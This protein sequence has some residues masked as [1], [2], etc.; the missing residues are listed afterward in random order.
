MHNNFLQSIDTSVFIFL[1]SF[2][3]C[4][5]L[6]YFFVAIT[7]IRFW[8]IPA[9]FAVTLYIAKERKHALLVI[10]LVLVTVA[11]SDPVSSQIFKHS[12][13]RLRPCN[14]DVLVPGGHFLFGIKN[15]LSFPS[16]HATNMFAV[17]AL[18][19]FF[20]PRKWLYF[21]GFASLIGFSRIYDGVHYPGDVL[22]GAVLGVIV[23]SLVY[24]CYNL[25]RKLRK[26]KT[27]SHNI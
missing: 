5:V 4:T 10:I 1:N 25:S 23:G 9:A 21:F 16:S 26:T 13:H 22:G 3:S 12:F 6:N 15:S 7:D 20:Y 8:L 11:I 19:T 14:I 27:L 18:F 2:L 24:F 17:A